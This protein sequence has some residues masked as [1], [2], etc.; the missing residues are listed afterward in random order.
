MQGTSASDC[1]DDIFSIIIR[2]RME[3]NRRDEASAFLEWSEHYDEELSEMYRT[4]VNPN[5]GISF[6][7]FVF[8]AYE[9]TE[10]FRK[11]PGNKQRRFLIEK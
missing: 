4:F 5:M 7:S 1:P 6:E 9:S 11:K 8:A 10:A 3:Q 2:V